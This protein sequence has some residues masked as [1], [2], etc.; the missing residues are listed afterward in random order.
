MFIRI[1]KNKGGSSSVMILTGER[2]PGKKHSM[3]RIVKNFGSGTNDA[4]IKSLVA[5][6]TQF[7][8]HLEANSPKAP[9]ALKILSSADLRSCSSFT[10]GFSDVYGPMFSRF[11]GDIKLKPAHLA[12]LKDLVTMRIAE[13]ASKLKT[14]YLAEDYGLELKV[15]NI[16]KLM[17]ELSEAKI[18]DIKKMVYKNT[19]ELLAEHKIETSVMF[20]DLTTLYFETNNDDDLRKNGFSKDGKHQHVQIMLA[21]IVTTDGLPIDYMHFPGNTYEGHTLIPALDKLKKEY[22]IT[23]VVLVADAGLMSKINLDALQEKGYEYIIAARIKSSTNDLKAQIIDKAD[24]QLIKE[25]KD[26]DGT[27]LDST[28]AKNIATQK[29]NI[30]AYYSTQRARKDAYDRQKNLDKIARYLDSTGKTKLTSGLQKSYIQ[31]TKECLVSIDPVKLESDKQLDGYFAI[32]TNI[33]TPDP[34][35]LLGHYRG[36]WQIEASFRISKHNLEIR[37]IYHYNTKRILAHL[38]IC[39]LSL[40]LLRYVEFILKQQQ[41]N[42]AFEKLCGMLHRMRKVIVTDHMGAQF[43]LLEDPPAAL[44]PI[45]QAL[46]IKWPKKFTNK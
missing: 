40:A 4:E 34:K 19:V 43:E 25:V 41:Q 8:A 10:T 24:Y 39:Y 16:Y 7:K 11:F 46:A 45:Y 21:M 26:Q 22:N 6:A 29:D 13:P 30:I 27:I 18:Q 36:L 32:R 38:S 44:I 20:Y 31:I 28:N 2:V 37:P 9:R 17:D 42:I 3:S 14:A 1:K 33:K 35:E 12:R 15:D 5:V 23:K